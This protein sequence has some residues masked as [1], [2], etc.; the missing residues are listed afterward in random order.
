MYKT[1]REN[2]FWLDYVIPSGVFGSLIPQTSRKS[3]FLYF[4]FW[5]AI[6]T[7]FGYS[8]AIL[9]IELSNDAALKN[10]NDLKK[11]KLFIY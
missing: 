2:L 7:Q 5:H 10:P 8:D 4:N 11:Q 3:F 6:Q 1:Q 9:A